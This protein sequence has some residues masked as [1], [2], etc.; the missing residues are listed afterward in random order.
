MIVVLVAK[1]DAFFLMLRVCVS[2]LYEGLFAAVLTYGSKT[3]VWSEKENSKTRLII[4][5]GRLE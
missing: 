1:V 5:N 2:V 4:Q 3:L